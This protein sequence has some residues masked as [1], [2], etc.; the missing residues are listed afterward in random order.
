MFYFMASGKIK[1]I[2][3]TNTDA[4]SETL[5]LL[6]TNFNVPHYSVC[7]GWVL[8]RFWG[9][10]EN[11]PYISFLRSKNTKCK[12]KKGREI[13]ERERERGR[14]CCCRSLLAF[15]VVV[16]LHHPPSSLIVLFVNHHSQSRFVLYVFFCYKLKKMYF[17]VFLSFSLV[18]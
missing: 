3:Q 7:I 13:V 11:S 2:V 10:S 8:Q 1:I 4:I 17:I 6:G 12:E 14:D 5:V 18:N 9:A 16:L 15:V